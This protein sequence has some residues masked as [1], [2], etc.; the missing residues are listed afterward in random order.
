MYD[1]KLNW[2]NRQISSGTVTVA[3]EGTV[4][5]YWTTAALVAAAFENLVGSTL[6]PNSGWGSINPT[7]ESIIVQGVRDGSIGALK[8]RLDD[9]VGGANRNAN[10][11]DADRAQRLGKAEP[12]PEG[13]DARLEAEFRAF[14]S[15]PV[16]PPASKP[17]TAGLRNT[18][19]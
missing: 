12:Q 9:L 7:T 13:L 19:F 1:V 8:N 17:Q 16:P 6:R 4:D 3:L 14:D 10:Q 2:N 18:Q 5:E 11:A 15:P